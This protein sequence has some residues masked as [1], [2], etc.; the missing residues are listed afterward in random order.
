MFRH[1]WIFLLV[2]VLLLAGVVTSPA[3]DPDDYLGD[4]AI[5]IGNPGERP[6]PN[7]LLLIDTSKSTLS[8]APGVGYN[9][10]TPYSS[11]MEFVNEQ[12]YVGDNFGKFALNGALGATL[13]DITCTTTYDIPDSDITKTFNIH[14][15]MATNGTYSGAGSAKFPNLTTDGSCDTAP[16]GEV[17]ATGNYLNY[18]NGLVA[19]AGGEIIIQHTY[20]YYKNAAKPEE[21]ATKNFRLIKDL[22]NATETSEPGKTSATPGTYDWELY[23]STTRDAPTYPIDDETGDWDRTDGWAIGTTTAYEVPFSA[24]ALTQREAF[25]EALVPV[26]TGASPTV[27]FGFMTYS[28]LNQGAALG[29]H[30]TTFGEDPSALIAL[31]P[32]IDS[33]GTLVGSAVIES[34]T[35]RPQSEALYDAG[36]YFMTN[37]GLFTP[38]YVKTDGTDPNKQTINLTPENQIPSDMI[39]ICGYNHII[40]L[41]NGLPNKDGGTPD[42]GDW[43]NDEYGDES[44][45]GA[46]THYLDDVAYYLH[47]VV[48]LNGDGKPGDITV[49]TILA[50]QTTD[51]LIQNTAEDGGGLFYNVADTNG[52][53]KALQE[54]LANIVSESDT[55]F[56]APV[57]PASSTNRTLSSNKVYL[58][59]FKPQTNAPW[60]GNLKKYKISADNEL[61]DVH[62]NNA[63][64]AD[65]DFVYSQSYWGTGIVDGDTKIL[66][67]DGARD[68]V[69]DNYTPT[70]PPVS[71]EAA[72]GGDGG[73]V[74][75]GGVGGTL[76]A[77][78]LAT[79]PRKIYTYLTPENTGGPNLNDGVSLVTTA[80]PILS[81]AQNA[82]SLANAGN[83]S[84]EYT[85]GVGS[86]QEEEKLIKYLHGYDA[87]S[88]TP[89][90]K[91]NWI[92][93]D[94]L[95]SKPLVFNYT[96]YTDSVE[97]TC[98]DFSDMT[99]AFNSTVI[100][101]GANDGMLHA[102]RDC[103]GEELWGFV[104]PSLLGDLKNL[105]MPGHEYYVDAPSSAYVHDFDNDGVIESGDGDVVILIFGLR[106]GGGNAFLTA[107]DSRGS[108]IALD[109]TDPLA[110]V[111]L[112]EIESTTSA[113]FSELG[114]TW[115]QPRLHK[116]MDGTTEKLV[117]FV[118]AGYD[119]NEDLRFGNTQTFPH[120]IVSSPV[121]PTDTDTTVL[122][123]DGDPGV[124]D[125]GVTSDTGGP[126]H[127]QYYPRGRGLYVIEVATLI[128][129]GNGDYTP[130]FTTSGSLVWKY[131]Y[132]ED[133][134]M[135]YSIPSD[136]AVLD[137]DGDGFADRVY[138]GDTGGQM[139]R[140]D[141]PIDRSGTPTGIKANWGGQIIFK[142][143]PGYTGAV[144]S[145]GT[146]SSSTDST[147]GKKI[148]Y[149]PSVAR[150][151]QYAT[152]YFGTGDREH[153]LNLASADRMYMLYDRGQGAASDN[154]STT[155]FDETTIITEAHM[156][157]VTAN[158]LQNSTVAAEVS[159]VLTE[160]HSATNFGWYIRLE[161]NGEKMLAPP[162]VFFGQVFYTTYAPVVGAVADCEVGNLGVSRL[163][164]LDFRTGEAVFNYDLTNDGDD[165]T[166][167]DRAGGGEGEVLKKT[168]R[169]R[170]LGEGIPSGIVTLIDASGKVTMMIS[171]SNRVGTYSAPDAKLITPVYW[172]QWND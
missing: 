66:S 80:N 27:N 89:N 17:Y 87:Y 166:A 170:T 165:I 14:N 130:S 34:P 118:G 123:N 148:F 128:K 75:A 58:G 108:Y 127:R 126:L 158:T 59:L 50:F 115:S 99:A 102:F 152:L 29:Y 145:D 101:V 40:L 23:W 96:N 33:S 161:N 43:D 67:A 164:H 169:V 38:K 151:G 49:H 26:I 48:D 22:P 160:L 104:P 31:L 69:P 36:Y 7:I 76:Q 162:V 21:I 97:S 41:T 11:S 150:V 134:D 105:P 116:V 16:K 95:H 55:A 132:E 85:L 146:V 122:S 111:F 112:W 3:L 107:A 88:T 37:N 62:G 51:E 143:N 12:I 129:D 109:V 42:L 138:A 4:S 68:P 91:R 60:H 121:E 82:L 136:L 93:G 119:N 153:P 113:D 13:S 163:Y 35:N 172:M 8:R 2:P 46:G 159:G 167:N 78:N 117:F 124:S 28:R 120:P 56:V 9:S 53:T 94:I 144:A 30:M 71:A 139:W 114:E 74:D 98:S 155:N 32:T 63:T 5:Y 133:T 90:A 110:P 79:N 70:D 57:V 52:L 135:T 19:V 156:V 64:D 83:I 65:G 86:A 92:F 45:Y 140:F 77:R 25:Y 157:D 149:R 61:L 103:D 154:V 18:I 10:A 168:D 125:A 24:N 39:N 141:L 142:A 131:T 6:T 73:I 81:A 106:R 100:Y 147:N 54:I 20:T 171:A 72:P 44:V 15:I 84:Y 47:N 137:W 1:L